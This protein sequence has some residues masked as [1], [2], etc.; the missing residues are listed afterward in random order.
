MVSDDMRMP[1]DQDVDV[2]GISHVG[3]V[4]D[5]NED[6]FLVA[7]LHKTIKVWNTSLVDRHLNDLAS[8]SI[9]FLMM[10]AD[11]VGGNVAGEVA[12]HTALDAVARYCTQTVSAYHNLD[13]RMEDGF[14]KELETSVQR[15]H[16]AVRAEAERNPTQRGMATTL[17]MVAVIWPQAYVVQ[18]G[19]SRCYRLRDGELTQLTTDQTLAQALIDQGAASEDADLSRIK[20]LLTSVIGS[21]HAPV[22][23][24][25][26]LQW[27]DVLM[28]CTDGLTN[29]LSDDKIRECLLNAGTA[30]EMSRSLVA[31]ALDCGGTDNVT[32][33]VGRLK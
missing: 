28:L 30:E 20:H 6:Q 7:S 10:V 22:T 33:V 15:C 26:S 18:V 16:Q 11:G 29:H 9:A 19:D 4:R 23:T 8:D 25:F 14:L 24:R 2:F 32:V 31:Q 13:A 27:D 5:N 3:K 17:T 1:E 12:S 21:K